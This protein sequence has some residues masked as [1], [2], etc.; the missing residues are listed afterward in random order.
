[1]RYC[2][3]ETADDGDYMVLNGLVTTSTAVNANRVLPVPMRT[4]PSY[5]GTAT[6]LEFQSYDTT[7][8]KHFDDGI[9][10][11]TPTTVPATVINLK[12]EVSGTTAG[13]FAMCR[14]KENG[15]QMIFSAEL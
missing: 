15:G 14:C 13:H 11:R 6:D 3:V 8:T 10:Y 12:W 5:T 1:M 9:V 7:N 2:Y 4:I